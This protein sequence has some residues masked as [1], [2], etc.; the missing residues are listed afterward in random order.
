MTRKRHRCSTTSPPTNRSAWLRTKELRRGI[1]ARGRTR[2]QQVGRSHRTGQTRQAPTVAHRSSVTIVA[3]Q[4]TSRAPRFTAPLQHVAAVIPV[5]SVISVTALFAVR[6]VTT[7]RTVR[8]TAAPARHPV[9]LSGEPERH[10]NR[11]EPVRRGGRVE[12]ERSVRNTR[13]LSRQAAPRGEARRLIDA[14]D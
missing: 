12:L 11:F 6:A 3:D 14:R 9:A 1:G 5:T 4:R 10:A 7:V 8:L 2:L 13:C